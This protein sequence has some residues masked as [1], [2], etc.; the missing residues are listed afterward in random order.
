MNN[1]RINARVG[2]IEAG[3]T[4]IVMGVGTGPNDIEARMVIPTS[5]PE[6]VLQNIMDWFADQG[7]ISALG[8]SSFGPLDLDPLSETWGHINKTT[9]PGWSN[10]NFAPALR[11]ALGVP[12]GIDTDVNGAAL[13]EARWGR[14][15]GADNRTSVY[16]TIGTGVGGGTVVNGLPMHGKGHPEMGHM[17]LPRHPADT[18]FAGI[19]PFHAD[20]CEGLVS[21][22]AILKRFGA[23][24]SDL[25]DTH[26]AHEM[27]AWYLAQLAVTLQSVLAPDEIILGGGVMKTPGLIERVRKVADMLAGD[28]FAVSPGSIIMAPALGD[29][30]GLLGA[31]VLAQ[32]AM[33]GA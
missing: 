28:Y 26:P 22:P 19:C 32:R 12:V 10:F 18:G 29:N 4:K 14:A 15:A 20:C 25:P 27:I 2:G 13:G 7:P 23:T 9:K 1:Y 31:F 6:T 16:V 3:G 30:S 21:G 33:E 17:R 24:L 8:I 5:S 11:A